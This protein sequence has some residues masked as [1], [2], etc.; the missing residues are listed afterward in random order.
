[1]KEVVIVGGGIVGLCC[2]WHLHEAGMRV[3][4]V[5]KGDF[6]EGCSFGNSGMI[7]PSHF[8]P[9]ASPGM[10]AKGLKWMFSKGSPFYIRPRLNLELA[11]W[12]WMFYRSASKKHVAE[13]APLLRD[14]HIEGRE[15]Y[16]QLNSKPGFDFHFDRKGI[17]MMYQT[18][19]GEHEEAETAEMAHELGIEANILSPDDL[20]I[21]D[22]GIAMNVRG[23][24]HFPGDAHLAPHVLMLQLI[25]SLRK[26]GVEFMG[27]SEV[28]RIDDQGLDGAIISLKN[29]EN[30]KAKDVVIATGTWSGILMKKSGFKLPMQDGK[31][32]SMTIHQPPGMPSVPAILTEARVAITPMGDKLRLAG[33]LEIS[34]RDEKINPHKVKSILSA[35]SNYYPE[36]KITDSRPVWYGYRPCTPDGMPCIGRLSKGSSILLATGHAMM[37]LSLAPATGRMVKDII[38]GKTQMEKVKKFHPLRF[39]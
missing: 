23:A 15:F 36:L 22:P 7:V 27:N 39:K 4:I 9:L 6:S 13:C 34:G 24:V 3:T 20:K 28:I 19:S 12:L 1:M 29:N 5:D 11:Q 8:I 33:T 16:Q 17:L 35:A 18:A 30:I 2:A 26:S 37:G 21:L 14:M 31:G 25:A 38:F 10:I 32:Y